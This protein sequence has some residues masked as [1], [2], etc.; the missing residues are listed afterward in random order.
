M[1]ADASKPI[2]VNQLASVV[3]ETNSTFHAIGDF[4]LL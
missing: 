3:T 4:A 2:E 1:P